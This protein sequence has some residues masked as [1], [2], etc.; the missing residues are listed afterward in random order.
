MSAAIWYI[1]SNFFSKCLI[2]FLT[3]FYARILTQTEYG[4]YS[5]FSSWQ[6]ILL[7]ILSLN[8]SSTV[9]T[10]Y[11]D[12]REKKEFNGYVS[13]ISAVSLIV[14][15]VLGTALFLFRDFLGEVLNMDSRLLSMLVV[16]LSFSNAIAIFQAEQRCKL[17]YQLSSCLTVFVAIL[18]VLNTLYFLYTWDNKLEAVVCGT[19]SANV[20]I[21]FI[22][23]VAIFLRSRALKWSYIKYAMAI[24]LP[25]IPHVV[26]GH[27]LGTS[28]K[29]MITWLCGS[30]STALY[31]IPYTCSMVITLLTTSVNGAWV[32]WFFSKLETKDYA[33]IK[34]VVRF[35]MPLFFVASTSLCLIAPEVMFLMGGSQY[36]G[37]AILMPPIILSC[38][39]N[40]VYTLYVNIE[41]YNK[42]TG[43]I[44][45]ATV[46]AASIN[47]IL[48]YVFIKVFGYTGAAY[49]TLLSNL[50]MLI[51][52]MLVVKRQN[53]LFVFDNQFNI[54]CLAIIVMVG[55]LI[56]PLYWHDVLRYGVIT[57]FGV[58]IC[59]IVGRYHRQFLDA[60]KKFITD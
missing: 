20:L 7:A 47:V 30:E 53:M 3:P 18:S 14:P 57:V 56:L 25:L 13:A 54:S 55:L 29:V 41:F 6:T 28:D 27:I 43:W 15:L 33:S 10:A 40:Y 36:K 44:S 50:I 39:C 24:A 45:T 16:S 26:A 23:Y 35:M 59:V 51:V 4:Q 2:F 34:K 49:T 58:V 11:L 17:K 5:N 19:I 8:L 46:M 12:Y 32:P 38:V 22:V 21:N 52:H 60:F 37:A 48:N 31:S 42:K 1:I 9:A